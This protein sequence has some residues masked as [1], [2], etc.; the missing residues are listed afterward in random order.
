MSGYPGHGYR[1]DSGAHYCGS[2]C[3]IYVRGVWT[4]VTTGVTK[5]IV[6]VETINHMP[7]VEVDM[8]VAR[9]REA[10]EGAMHNMFEM[11]VYFRCSLR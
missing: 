10:E 7:I 11:G 2:D 1:G 3:E 6:L 4:A 5:M 9:V 8:T